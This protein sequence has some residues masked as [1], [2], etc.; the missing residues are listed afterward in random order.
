MILHLPDD[1]QY[2]LF[3]DRTLTEMIEE[4]EET[5]SEPTSRKV[6]VRNPQRVL[7]GGTK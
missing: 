5:I 4:Y 7:D 1:L 3:N 2:K 6:I